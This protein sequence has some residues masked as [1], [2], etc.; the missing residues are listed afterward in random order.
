MAEKAYGLLINY[1]CCT[2]CMSCEMACSVEHDIPVGQYGIKMVEVGPW[3]I[4]K[5]NWQLDYVPIPTDMC[6]LCAGRVAKG[7][8]PTCV[9]HCQSLCMEY[10]PVDELAAKMATATTKNVLYVP[11]AGTVA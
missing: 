9:K 10:G 4:D 1:E 8:K 7:K 11:K 3:Q 2:G 6:D 5:K